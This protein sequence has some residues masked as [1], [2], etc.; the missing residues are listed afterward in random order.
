MWQFAH[1]T[2]TS[3][4]CNI[5]ATS[6]AGEGESTGAGTSSELPRAWDW[7]AQSW[8]PSTDRQTKPGTPA[9]AGGSQTQAVGKWNTSACQ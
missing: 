9:F 4:T 5:T 8:A 2:A 6:R 1:E 7:A 3:M